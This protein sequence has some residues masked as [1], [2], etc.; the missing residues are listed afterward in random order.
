MTALLGVIAILAILS[1]FA[2]G[3]LTIVDVARTTDDSIVWRASGCPVHHLDGSLHY[4]CKK[5]GSLHPS[6]KASSNAH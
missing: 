2:Q 4:L 1:P 5:S 6:A 3:M